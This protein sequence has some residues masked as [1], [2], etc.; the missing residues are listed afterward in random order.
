MAVLLRPH[1][2]HEYVEWPRWFYGPDG[3]SE[4]FNSM[5]EVPEGWSS[6]QGKEDETD[7]EEELLQ[8]SESGEDDEDD[9]DDEEAVTAEAVAQA[10]TQD[11]LIGLIDAANEE[12]D[13]DAQI[14]YLGNW[15]KVRLA[16]ALLDGGVTIELPKE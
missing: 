11:A 4:I 16:Q 7:A 13:E 14:E 3:Q 1:P 2:P 10:F 12:R 5:D 15:S 6:T 8:S 9:G